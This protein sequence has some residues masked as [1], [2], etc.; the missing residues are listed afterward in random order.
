MCNAIRIDIDMNTS[1]YLTEL[2]KLL[3]NDI[4]TTIK[5]GA[6]VDEKHFL[7]KASGYLRKMYRHGPGIGN[8]PMHLLACGLNRRESEFVNKVWDEIRSEI[9]KHI[10]ETVK[11]CSSKKMVTEIRQLAARAI[12]EEGMNNAGMKCLII[13]QTYRA[14]VAV[15]V[16]PKNKAV[17]YISYK[18]TAEDLE[19]CIAGAKALTELLESF[20]TGASIEKMMPYENWFYE[21]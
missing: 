10:E 14:K 20:G 18:K 11:Q 17:F 5:S 3:T 19:R 13:P 6:T 7:E 1:E 8:L 9:E 21:D 15:R 16:S 2:K 12:I 4:R